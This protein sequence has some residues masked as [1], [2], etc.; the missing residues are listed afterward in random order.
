MKR[1]NQKSLW[2]RLLYFVHGRI[3]ASNFENTRIGTYIMHWTDKQVFPE[4]YQR[5]G[6]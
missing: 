5:R 6:R 3:G 1:L 2:Q 4:E